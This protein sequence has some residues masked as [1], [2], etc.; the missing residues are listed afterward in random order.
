MRNRPTPPALSSPIG[1]LAILVG[2]CPIVR[3]NADLVAA[4]LQHGPATAAD[5]QRAVADPKH[6][7]LALALLR[8]MGAVDVTPGEGRLVYQL[9]DGLLGDLPEG[10]AGDRR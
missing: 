4:Q 9:A 2:R 5:L 10:V 6:L 1:V 3:S 8:E 7:G